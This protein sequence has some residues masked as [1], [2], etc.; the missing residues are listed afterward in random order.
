MVKILD[1]LPLLALNKMDF[2]KGDTVRPKKIDN[3]N[4]VS[5]SESTLCQGP[6][7]RSV[8]P[9]SQITDHK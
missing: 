7:P 6:L 4:D 9:L 5:L 8:K 3:K 1:V 2:T